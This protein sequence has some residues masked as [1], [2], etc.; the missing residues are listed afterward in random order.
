VIPATVEVENERVVI[1]AQPGQ[2][3]C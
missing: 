2:K 3:V 1:P